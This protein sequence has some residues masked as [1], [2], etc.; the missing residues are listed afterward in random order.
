MYKCACIYIYAYRISLFGARDT[1]AVERV[2]VEVRDFKACKL[3][4]LSSY[5]H[6]R[7]SVRHTLH[8]LYYMRIAA[9]PSRAGCMSSCSL[10]T[11]IT[12][13][14]GYLL[15]YVYVYSG[16]RIK[17]PRWSRVAWFMA[18]AAAAVRE[19]GTDANDVYSYYV[20]YY[21]YTY[22]I[23]RYI[24]LYCIFGWGIY[25]H[26]CDEIRPLYD[27]TIFHISYTY[28]NHMPRWPIIQILLYW[29]R[30]DVFKIQIVDVYCVCFWDF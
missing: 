2:E 21:Y 4:L 28:S 20:Y 13:G 5:R 16:G 10:A 1:R 24:T 18:A 29:Y 26:R 11:I 19:H 12:S 15:N 17:L 30:I 22:Y 8:L 6:E 7:P 27:V 3:T 23:G 14:G 9:A 25:T